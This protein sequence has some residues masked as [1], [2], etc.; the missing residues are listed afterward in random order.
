MNGTK[1]SGTTVLSLVIITSIVMLLLFLVMF[2]VGFEQYA[3]ASADKIGA[4]TN[5]A[6]WDERHA[7]IV[8]GDSLIFLT[9]GLIFMAL[10]LAVH[11]KSQNER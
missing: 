11:E 8:M 10:A 3:D 9:L 1:R 5:D 6:R 2:R 4:Y 7:V